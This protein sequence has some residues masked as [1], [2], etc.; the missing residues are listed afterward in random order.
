MILL[1]Y[2]I[3]YKTYSMKSLIIYFACIFITYVNFAQP[4][5][6]SNLSCE[7]S[8]DSLILDIN[9]DGIPDFVL[10]HSKRSGLFIFSREVDYTDDYVTCKPLSGTQ[11]TRCPVAFGTSI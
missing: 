8:A 5:S 4:H 1:L 3:I 7:I 10:K 2:D 6:I 9:S 11:Y